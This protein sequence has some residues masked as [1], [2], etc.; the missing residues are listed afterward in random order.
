MELKKYEVYTLRYTKSACESTP[1]R[2]VRKIVHR[3]PIANLLQHFG[4]SEFF[5]RIGVL[6]T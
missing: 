1:Y 3:V 6:K 5:D 4:I 2:M